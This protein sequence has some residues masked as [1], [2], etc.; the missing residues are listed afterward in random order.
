[1]NLHAVGAKRF[2]AVDVGAEVGD[3]LSGVFVALQSGVVGALHD[4]NCLLLSYLKSTSHYEC[5]RCRSVYF[6]MPVKE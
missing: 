4:Y 3:F 5:K 1:M 6:R 2:Q